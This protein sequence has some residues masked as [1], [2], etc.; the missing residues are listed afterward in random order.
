MHAD[1]LITA[2]VEL[3]KRAQEKV[4]PANGRFVLDSGK[5]VFAAGHR[6]NRFLR[7]WFLTLQI[8][9]FIIR[10]GLYIASPPLTINILYG[11]Q[12]LLA[13]FRRFHNRF[14]KHYHNAAHEKRINRRQVIISCQIKI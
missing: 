14:S 9:S 10:K 11:N 7:F 8:E 3:K 12:Q 6:C 1:D 2:G 4:R 13:F 5:H